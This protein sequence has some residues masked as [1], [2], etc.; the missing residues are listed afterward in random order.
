MGKARKDAAIVCP[1]QSVEIAINADDKI[2]VGSRE[3][4][5]FHPTHKRIKDNIPRCISCGQ[6]DEDGW[7][8]AAYCPGMGGALPFPTSTLKLTLKADS[9]FRSECTQRITLEQWVA[10]NRL[11]NGEAA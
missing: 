6:I 7:H 11:L 4:L 3:V 9:G 10:I 8:E 1:D 5:R 2:K